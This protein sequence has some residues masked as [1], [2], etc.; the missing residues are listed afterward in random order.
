MDYVL[1]VFGGVVGYPSDDINKFLWMVS[2][3]DREPGA[4]AW[5]MAS[6]ERLMHGPLLEHGQGC[7]KGL[8]WRM[9]RAAVWALVGAWAGLLHGPLLLWNWSPGAPQP[10]HA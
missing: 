7:C 6:V 9:C 8:C 3:L 2:G 4:E 10:W 1:V 5:A